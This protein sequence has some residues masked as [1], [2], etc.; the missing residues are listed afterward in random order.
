MSL[1][2][3][4]PD[5]SYREAYK[6]ACDDDIGRLIRQPLWFLE[7]VY[8]CVKNKRLRKLIRDRKW[9]IEN[10]RLKAEE[11][12]YQR[13]L[14]GF[15]GMEN[16]SVNVCKR[17]IKRMRGPELRAFK[18]YRKEKKIKGLMKIIRQREIELERKWF[19][20]FPKN[21]S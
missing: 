21:N 8:S 17:L 13:H 9:E 15:R 14:P 10:E 6:I 4:E 16:R 3:E 18:R 12:N 11:E 19:M 20:N 2:L 1:Y 5:L 7:N